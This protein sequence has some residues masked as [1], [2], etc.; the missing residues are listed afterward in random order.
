MCFPYTSRQELAKAA[1]DALAAG[2][3]SETAIDSHLYTADCPPV[4]LLIRTSGEIRLSDFLLW[5]CNEDTQIHFIPVYWPEF[6]FLDMLRTLLEYN[7]GRTVTLER[8]RQA[9]LAAGL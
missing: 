2:D 7:L 1:S 5:Q 8:A 9:E 4:D 6:R 3:T